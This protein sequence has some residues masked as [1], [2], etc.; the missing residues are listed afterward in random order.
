MNTTNMETN[1]PRL[2]TVAAK[3]RDIG[4][5]TADNGLLI[6]AGAVVAASVILRIVAMRQLF[7]FGPPRVMPI[8]A[9]LGALVPILLCAGL[10]RKIDRL[11]EQIVR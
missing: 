4:E 3:V 9:G 6:A 2:G 10:S 5:A 1:G 11:K 8:A 7:R